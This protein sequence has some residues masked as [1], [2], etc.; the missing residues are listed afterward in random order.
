[1]TPALQPVSP[2]ASLRPKDVGRWGEDI[3]LAVL[4][5]QGYT[6][7][8]R[9]WRPART[10]ERPRWSGELDLIMRDS[11]QTLVFIEVKTRSGAGYGHPLESITARKCQMLRHL[12]YAWL[13]E[14]RA[15]YTTMRVDAIALCGS[16]MDF[17][18]EHRQAVV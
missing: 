18:F 3:A 8:A 9:N 15:P 14:N 13:A 1:M 12:A 7:L 11:D 4:E 6:L 5:Q 10:E 17:T 2:H 16:P